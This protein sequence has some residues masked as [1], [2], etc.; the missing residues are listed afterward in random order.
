[1]DSEG[2]ETFLC[3]HR[4]GSVS[5]AAFTLS[6]T[7]SAISRRLTVL[8]EQAGVP[9]F[10]R[11]GRRLV[12]SDAGKA[13]LPYA[14]RVAA[15]VADARSA[16]QGLRSGKLGAL[17]I[18]AVGTLADSRLTAALHEVRRQFPG[19]DLQLRTA[20][21]AQVSDLVRTG[22][23]TVGLRYFDERSPDLSAQRVVTERLVVACSNDHPLARRRVPSLA[24][25]AGERW[26]AFPVI[27]RHEE[28][29]A[30][31][32]FAQFMSRGIAQV[33]WTAIDSLTAQK[34]LVEAGLGIALMQ[35]SAIREEVDRR[36]LA[37]I[38]VDDLQVEV[39]VVG[40]TRRG[41]GVSP[42]AKALLA[43]V[44]AACKQGI[45]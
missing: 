13:L 5:A 30:G 32:V 25:L 7:Q 45:A 8:E 6:R 27:D 28:F 17:R 41:A 37:T 21:S 14:E 36:Q 19:V 34:R 1:M 29:F 16:A 40:I 44:R 2:L 31:S 42:A 3:V 26:L 12:M 18:A 35:D 9:L 11:V 22:E 24:K 23:A 15:A 10:E 4:T 20:T 43:A 33:E 38:R 39:P